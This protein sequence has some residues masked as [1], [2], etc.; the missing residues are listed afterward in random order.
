M[1]FIQN[2]LA[3]LAD[4]EA[5]TPQLFSA[6]YTKRYIMK[7][8]AS[9]C[10]LDASP[11]E[12]GRSMVEMLG[13]LAIIGVLSVG[14]I[15]GYSK[16]MSKYKLNKQAEQI[17]WLL[18]AMYRYKDLLG[19]NQPWKSF[20]PYL[21]KLGE[22]PQEMIKDSSIYLYDSFGMKYEMKTNGCTPT[23]NYT[24]LSINMSNDYKNFDICNNIL[25]TSKAFAEQLDNITIW[26]SESNTGLGAI[27]G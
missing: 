2:I 11:K 17:S 14:A 22:I 7:K 1:M 4:S 6:V 15:A 23:C 10:P 24:N 18:N 9:R 27:Q 3:K 21:K 25:E 5:D 12:Q 26:E 19:Q 20:V 16:A 13:V 8:V